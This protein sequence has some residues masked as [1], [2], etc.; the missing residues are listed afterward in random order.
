MPQATSID[1]LDPAVK[2]YVEHL[3]T[4]I[5][6]SIPTVEIKVFTCAS[7]TRFEFHINELRSKERCD[8]FLLLCELHTL[9]QQY[10]YSSIT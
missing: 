6:S 10:T 4:F 7:Y 5:Q 8:E 9:L 3:I 1:N 2:V